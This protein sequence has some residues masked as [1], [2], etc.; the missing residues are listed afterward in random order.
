MVIAATEHGQLVLERKN[1]ENRF[2]LSKR[3]PNF[4]FSELIRSQCSIGIIYEYL[5]KSQRKN[6]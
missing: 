1:Q 3:M 5:R 4:N 6:S 2:F